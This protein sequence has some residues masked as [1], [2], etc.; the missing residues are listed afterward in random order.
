MDGVTSLNGSLVNT[1]EKK[2]ARTSAFLLSVVANNLMLS[3]KYFR[4]HI[5][6]VVLVL[7]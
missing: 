3:S 2:D 7:N 5:H 1:G 4:S 6:D